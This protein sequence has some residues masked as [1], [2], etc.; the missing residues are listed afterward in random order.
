MKS[1][2]PSAHSRRCRRDRRRQRRPASQRPPVSGSPA[3]TPAERARRSAERWSLIGSGWKRLSHISTGKARVTALRAA[4]D[5]YATAERTGGSFYPGLNRIAC[6]L[7]LAAVGGTESRDDLDF[8]L[9]EVERAAAEADRESADFWTGVGM[10]EV[11]V[12]R[13]LVHSEPPDEPDIMRQYAEAWRRG[14]SPQK[15]RSV[16]EQLEWLGE[17]LNTS[18]LDSIRERIAAQRME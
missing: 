13:G 18:S 16:L 7:A 14:G 9:R 2:T 4:A 11:A 15:L 17:C 12:L 5:A 6:E 3:T 8:A 10:A 1:A